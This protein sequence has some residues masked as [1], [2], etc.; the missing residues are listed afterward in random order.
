MDAEK[1]VIR[2]PPPGYCLESRYAKY[3]L[4]TAD[5]DDGGWAMGGGA[6]GSQ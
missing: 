3:Y 1:C 5:L 6:S 2:L 4:R